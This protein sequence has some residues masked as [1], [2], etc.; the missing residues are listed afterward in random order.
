MKRVLT[1]VLITFTLTVP[2]IQPATAASWR[3]RECRFQSLDGRW[4]WTTTEVE[5]TIR[6]LA[7]K[8]GIS[9]SM[10]LMVARHESG[11]RADPPGSVHCGVYQHVRSYFSGRLDGAERR[12]PGLAWFAQRCETARSNILAAFYLV[13]IDGWNAHWCD[14]VR[15]C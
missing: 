3:W 4:G 2:M 1:A 5:R 10:A 8:L 9:T 7:P 12:W 15:Y 14:H 13:K 6:C 11:L